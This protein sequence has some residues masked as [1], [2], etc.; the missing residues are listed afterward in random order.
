METAIKIIKA[1]KVEEYIE[2]PSKYE[3]DF[4]KEE[5]KSED[6]KE[7]NGTEKKADKSVKEK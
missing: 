6:K 1:G 5:V 7:Q 3:Q 2:K 4:P